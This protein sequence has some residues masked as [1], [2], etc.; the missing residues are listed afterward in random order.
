[1]TQVCL[2]YGRR[3]IRTERGRQGRLQRWVDISVKLKFSGQ[4]QWGTPCPPPFP[5]PDQRIKGRKRVGLQ[6]PA[7]IHSSLNINQ[8]VGSRRNGGWYGFW[9]PGEVQWCTVMGCGCAFWFRRR[10]QPSQV[11]P[12][13]WRVEFK[14]WW[15][16]GDPLS[17]MSLD[18]EPS[19]L[20]VW[21][22]SYLF[23]KQIPC[24]V[25]VRNELRQW[26]L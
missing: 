23:R 2:S 20:I 7:G 10:G 16:L 9:A 22:A 18:G 5:A 1:M 4:A 12:E 8:G 17:T 3:R 21:E 19:Y 11:I 14:S 25:A 13:L 15:R 24:K 6:S 26:Y